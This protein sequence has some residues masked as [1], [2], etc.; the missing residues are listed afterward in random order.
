M[1]ALDEMKEWM[2]SEFLPFLSGGAVEFLPF[3]KNRNISFYFFFRFFFAFGAILSLLTA[4]YY[5][6]MKGLKAWLV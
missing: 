3:G 4:I 5:K 1:K 2:S 6:Y